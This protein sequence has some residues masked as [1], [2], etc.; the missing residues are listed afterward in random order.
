[1]NKKKEIMNLVLD[2]YS[3]LELR[4]H[5]NKKWIDMSE[6][7]LWQE[8]CLC[9]LSSNVPY[10]LALSAFHHLKKKGYL[11][12]ELLKK[13]SISKKII[14]DELSRPVYLPKK[15]DGGYRKYRFPKTR[16]RNIIQAAKV[17]AREEDWIKKVL[18]RSNS[19]GKVRGLLVSEISGIG[20]KE[21]S[22]FLRNI[23]Y[24]KNLAIVDSHV[25]SFLQQIDAGTQR[26]TKTMT[27][28]TYFELE[29]QIQEIC[30][31]YKLDL[32]IFDMA[33]WHFMRRK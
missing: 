15:K 6:D 18:L 1:M 3:K 17:I 13:E 11:R 16:A 19:E 14:T 25:V 5:R 20:L 21:A 24:S 26:K 4:Y 2:E 27:R 28:N 9:I 29:N 31:E 33:I 12:L 7:E 8:L 22:H 30:S 32:S 23:K 10:E